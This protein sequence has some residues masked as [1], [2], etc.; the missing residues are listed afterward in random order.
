VCENE[1]LKFVENQN[2][3]NLNEIA[4][5]KSNFVTLV[6]DGELVLLPLRSIGARMTEIFNLK[7]IQEGVTTE[8]L[9][10]KILSEYEVAST[11][12]QADVE[13]FLKDRSLFILNY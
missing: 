11:V 2:E 4:T 10:E 8:T 13:E 7:E 3:M 6:V 5:A 1:T 12:A 9:T